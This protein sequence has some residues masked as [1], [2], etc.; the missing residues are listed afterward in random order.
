MSGKCKEILSRFDNIK[1]RQTEHRTKI[2][3]RKVIVH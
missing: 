3:K 2:E 1:F